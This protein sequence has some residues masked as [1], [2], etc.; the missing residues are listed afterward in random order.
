MSNSSGPWLALTVLLGTSGC[1]AQAD[2]G[3]GWRSPDGAPRVLRL[4]GRS[5]NMRAS[6]PTL[7]ARGAATIEDDRLALRNAMVAVGY[8]FRPLGPFPDG[9]GL[10]GSLELGMGEPLFVDYR[11]VG[12]Y[13][14]G[15]ISVPYRICGDADF[16]PNQYVSLAVLVDLVASTSFGVWTP[17]AGSSDATALGAL[18]GHFGVRV[19]FD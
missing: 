1:A 16:D 9:L 14:G 18:G 7:G 8:Q 4:S 13:V 10:D 5:T 6:G 17:P 19:T 15:E 12:G 3:Y 11:G 2:V